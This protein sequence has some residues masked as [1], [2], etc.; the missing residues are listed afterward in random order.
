MSFPEG[1]NPL[2]VSEVDMTTGS[3]KYRKKPRVNKIIELGHIQGLPRFTRETGCYCDINLVFSS[4]STLESFLT[5]NN[6]FKMRNGKSSW[7]QPHHHRYKGCYYTDD[8]P[9]FPKTPIY[10][11]SKGRWNHNS[12]ADSLLEMGFTDFHIIVE[13]SEY[14]KYAEKYD[15]RLLLILPQRV[16][17]EFEG[18]STLDKAT[19]GHG[20]PPARNWAWEHSM[21]NGHTHHMIIDDNCAG[22]VRPAPGNWRISVKTPTM[23]KIWEDAHI[24]AESKGIRLSALHYRFFFA[25]KRAFYLINNRVY[26][27]IMV[28]NSLWDEGVR[29]RV[30]RNEDTVLSLDVM[31]LGYKTVLFNMF[32]ANKAATLL[33]PGGNTA[34]VYGKYGGTEYKSQVLF[35][36]YPDIVQLTE[37]WGRPH[38]HID[39]KRHFG[40]G[41]KQVVNLNPEDPEYGLYVK[42]DTRED[43]YPQCLI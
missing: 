33:V 39:Y 10:I 9:V 40:S 30:S 6:I 3:V 14:V 4:E 1:L 5:E 18:E 31:T 13:E 19:M 23:F 24:S 22:F 12:T 20:S 34:N 17:D 26:S 27:I 7:Y 29:W 43:F 15:E 42:S 37:K 41:Y 21:A 2:L 32:L 8:N 25:G 35:N 28:T 36:E 11:P 16:I 38:H